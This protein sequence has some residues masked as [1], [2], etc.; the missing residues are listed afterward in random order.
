MFASIESLYIKIKLEYHNFLSILN[1]IIDYIL[2]LLLSYI[3]FCHYYYHILHFVIII[4]IYQ[5]YYH[6]LKKHINTS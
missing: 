3:T 1:N 2:S 5:F 6:M 4:I